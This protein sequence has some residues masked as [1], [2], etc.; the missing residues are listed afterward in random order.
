M[1]SGGEILGCCCC[2][3]MPGHVA[4]TWARPSAAKCAMWWHSAEH[5]LMS[6]SGFG[7]TIVI[8]FATSALYRAD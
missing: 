4:L 6:W 1:Q 8:D 3:G 7:R 2:N 5:K